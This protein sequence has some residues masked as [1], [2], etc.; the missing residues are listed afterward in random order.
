MSEDKYWERI[1]ALN[2]G[3]DDLKPLRTPDGDVF[4]VEYK[5]TPPIMGPVEQSE[6][7]PHCGK[8]G[9]E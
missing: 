3:R 7:C 2:P 9:I 8:A 6:P 5:G 1:L 4:A